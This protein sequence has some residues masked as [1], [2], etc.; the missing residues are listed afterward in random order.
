LTTEL[1]RERIVQ[2]ALIKEKVAEAD[3]E[4]LWPWHL[5]SVAASEDDIKAVEARLGERLDDSYRTFLSLAGGWVTFY[6][7]VDLFGCADLVGGPR[8]DRAREL[9]RALGEG[10]YRQMGFT[11]DGLLPIGASTE[12]LDLFLMARRHT[13]APGQVIWLAQSVVDVFPSFDDYFLTMMDYNR[14]EYST[15]LREHPVH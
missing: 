15:L 8:F 1:W 13:Q 9:M 11:A 3:V 6:Q 2:M 10:E 5:P 12:E 7:M 4:G 14:R